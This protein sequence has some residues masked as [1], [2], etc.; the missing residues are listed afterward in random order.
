MKKIIL[1]FLTSCLLTGC[2][3]LNKDT[4][5][6]S[7]EI[8]STSQ[9]N[10]DEPVKQPTLAK[11]QTSL[12]KIN[13]DNHPSSQTAIQGFLN[14][15]LIDNSSYPLLT[16]PAGVPQ[17]INQAMQEYYQQNLSQSDKDANQ[18]ALKPSQIDKLDQ[19]IK[20]DNSL[21]QLDISID[22]VTL[23]LGNG[24]AYVPRI[25]VPMAYQKANQIAKDNDTRLI[26]HALTVLDNRLV[27][28]AYYD[29]NKAQLIPMHLV[30]ASHSIF[31]YQDQ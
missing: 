30:N 9:E 15:K 20:S 22:Q 24:K 23:D 11:K 31:F 17:N 12:E 3:L 19:I 18:T 6:L 8:Q 26:N 13:E 2:H 25:I 4:S 5:N 7:K 1:F 27:L 16:I 28:I 14:E 21:E 10:T 29:T